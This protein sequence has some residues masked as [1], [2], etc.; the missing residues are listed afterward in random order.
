LGFKYWGVDIQNQ[1]EHLIFHATASFS[2]VLM[3][4]VWKVAAI[5]PVSPW[6]QPQAV[7]SVSKHV[8]TDYCRLDAYSK[9][10]ARFSQNPQRIRAAC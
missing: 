7:F 9:F 5:S 1:V 3:P 4:V 10:P 2:N 8:P 6:T